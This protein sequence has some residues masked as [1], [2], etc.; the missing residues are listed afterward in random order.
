M[1]KVFKVEGMSCMHCVMAIKK[2]VSKVPGV[3]GVDVDLEKRTVKA[4]F[5]PALAGPDQ[6]KK[7]IETAG[8]RVME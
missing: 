1:D 2:S 5:D 8:Y 6:V 3:G 7:A 4:T